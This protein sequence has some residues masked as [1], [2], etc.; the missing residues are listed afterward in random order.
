V[1]VLLHMLH[2][3]HLAF[4]SHAQSSTIAPRTMVDVENSDAIVGQEMHTYP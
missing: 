2:P 1:Q 4:S 3:Q